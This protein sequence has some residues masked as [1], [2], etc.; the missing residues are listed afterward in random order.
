MRTILI[1]FAILLLLL[2]LLGAFGGSIKY[3]EP[4]YQVAK[5]TSDE[6]DFTQD[7]QPLG[8]AVPHSG[9]ENQDDEDGPKSEFYATPPPKALF[10]DGLPAGGP[11]TTALPA[12]VPP[13]GAQVGASIQ[14]STNAVQEGFFIEP[15][16]EDTYSSVPSAY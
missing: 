8:H 4:F 3:S 14:P 15:F 9:F 6:E 1:V 16:E 7:Q 5:G 12:S 11:S 13:T 10:E 2:T